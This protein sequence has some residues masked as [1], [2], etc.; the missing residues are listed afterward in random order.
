MQRAIALARRAGRVV[1]GANQ[2]VR[3]AEDIGIFLIIPDMVAGGEKIDPAV[4]QLIVDFYGN[5]GSARGV[6][7][8]GNHYVQG[9]ALFHFGQQLLNNAAPGLTDDVA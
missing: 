2:I 5:A 7:D 8:I 6:F 3:N 9:E 4:F 1:G